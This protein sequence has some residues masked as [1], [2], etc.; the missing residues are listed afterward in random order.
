M[1]VLNF[2]CE[3]QWCISSCYQLKIYQLPHFVTSERS[4]QKRSPKLKVQGFNNAL[5]RQCRDRAV[6]KNGVVMISRGRPTQVPS[7]PPRI[8]HEI[9]WASADTSQRLNCVVHQSKINLKFHA[10]QNIILIKVA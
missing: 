8:S 9:S 5:S 2:T 1:S 4:G 7:A 3:L 10:L 6:C